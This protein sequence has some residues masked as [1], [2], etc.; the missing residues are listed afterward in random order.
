MLSVANERCITGISP[1]GDIG[2]NNFKSM[3]ALWGGAIT[4]AI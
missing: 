2:A 3:K 1:N 4:H